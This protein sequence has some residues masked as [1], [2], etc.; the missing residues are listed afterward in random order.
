MCGLQTRQ[1]CDLCCNAAELTCNWTT[2]CGPG[3]YSHP[4]SS[5]CLANP[6][7]DFPAPT[8]FI[9]INNPP[10]VSPVQSPVKLPPIQPPVQSPVES[11]AL[12]MTTKARPHISASFLKC[13]NYYSSF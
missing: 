9:P 2:T 5:T 1:A 6:P 3:Q 4:E 8:N 12:A 7:T 13:P 11:P 10:S